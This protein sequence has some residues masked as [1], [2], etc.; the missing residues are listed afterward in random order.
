M[1]CEK[2][3]AYSH[4]QQTKLILM[5]TG[6][7]LCKEIEVDFVEELSELEGFNAILVVTKQF[8]KVQDYIMAKTTWIGEYVA[9]SDSNHI[10]KLYLLPRHITADQGPQFQSKFLKALKRKLNI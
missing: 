6:K 5:P 3:E 1:K 9:I 2:C 8:S 10:W 4:F 7:A